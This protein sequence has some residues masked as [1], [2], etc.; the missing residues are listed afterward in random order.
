MQLPRPP[1][2]GP[3]PRGV[4]VPGWTKPASRGLVFETE[5]SPFSALRLDLDLSQGKGVRCPE[6]GF[7][8]PLPYFLAENGGCWAAVE[9]LRGAFLQDY[10]VTFYILLDFFVQK[11]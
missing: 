9:F 10:W 8:G 6:E 5:D 11:V 7:V 3:R 4:Q 1:A 2:N